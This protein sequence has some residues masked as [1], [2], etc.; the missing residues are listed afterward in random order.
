MIEERTSLP[1]SPSHEVPD[2]LQP[3]L[4]RFLLWLLLATL[5]SIAIA[6]LS[7]NVQAWGLAPLLLTSLI[8]GGACGGLLVVFARRVGAGQR[9]ALLVASLGLGLLAAG[10]QHAFA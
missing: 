8:V 5:T 9:R 3:S 10:M 1:E 4:G 6:W 2:K 7:V